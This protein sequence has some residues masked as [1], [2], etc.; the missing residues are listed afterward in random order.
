MDLPGVGQLVIDIDG[1]GILEEFPEPSTGIGESPTGCL[2]PKL[3]E[4][5][6]NSFFLGFVHKRAR[7]VMGDGH[8]SWQGDLHMSTHYFENLSGHKEKLASSFRRDRCFSQSDK[9][10]LFHRMVKFTPNRERIFA[11]LKK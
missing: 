2:D 7:G 10:L 6:L 5:L 3:I 8:E 4:R 1:G 9:Q 11:I